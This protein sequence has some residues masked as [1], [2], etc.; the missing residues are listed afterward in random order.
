MVSIH[1]N[2]EREKKRCWDK[3]ETSPF[4]LKRSLV[5]TQL[6]PNGSIRPKKTVP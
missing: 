4:C 5:K 6:P 3:K 1:P 2:E